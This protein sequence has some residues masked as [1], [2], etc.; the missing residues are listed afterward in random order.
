MLQ[1]AWS[2]SCDAPWC[3]TEFLATLHVP[4]REEKGLAWQITWQLKYA[5]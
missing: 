3:G 5:K 1:M 2:P 4:L